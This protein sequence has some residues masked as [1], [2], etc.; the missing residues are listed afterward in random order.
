[1]KESKESFADMETE[2][3]RRWAFA[4]EVAGGRDSAGILGGP[5]LERTVGG[6]LGL[7]FLWALLENEEKE[8]NEESALSGHFRP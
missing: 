4:A 8:C 7:E 6:F 1:M 2:G 5:K 3:V